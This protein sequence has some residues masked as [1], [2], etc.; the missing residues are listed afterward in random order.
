MVVL[1]GPHLQGAQSLNCARHLA[2]HNIRV[3]TFVP[4]LTN[5]PDL[6]KAELELLL[7]SRAKVVSETQGKFTPLEVQAV[8][9]LTLYIL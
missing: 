8:S 6:V 3:I 7:L 4:T 9:F 5:L 1:A 2:C